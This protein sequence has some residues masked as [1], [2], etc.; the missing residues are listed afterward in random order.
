MSKKSSFIPNLKDR[1]DAG[2]ELGRR[3]LAEKIKRPIVVLGLPRGGVP[4]AAAVAETL[5][6]KLDILMV[7]KIGAPG[8]EE[9]ACGAIASGGITVW[10]DEVLRSLGLTPQ[11]LQSTLRAE[12]AELVAREKLLRSAA[13]PEL[14]LRGH[15]V[16]LV[17]DGVATGATMRAAV[18]AVK[19]HL[20]DAIIVGL[21]VGPIDTCQKLEREEGAK[22]ICVHSIPT[23]N[24]GS[25]GQWYTDFSQVENQECRE[26]L[27]RNREDGITVDRNSALA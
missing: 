17:D 22:V 8:H 11:D 25:V 16:V 15:S 27:R 10:N 24:F 5:G 9:L 23:G 1:T 2:H 7:R 21:P 19:S 26:I 4:V 3:L 20:P 12:K 18:Q 6:A 14:S 13:T